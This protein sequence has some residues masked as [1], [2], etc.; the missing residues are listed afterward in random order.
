ME[1]D[2]KYIDVPYNKDGKTHSL[3]VSKERVLEWK[4]LEEK[5][6]PLAIVLS[7]GVFLLCFLIIMILISVILGD[8]YSRSGRG[9]QT[10]KTVFFIV[11]LP[12]IMVLTAKFYNFFKEYSS[13]QQ[14]KTDLQKIFNSRWRKINWV[15]TILLVIKANEKTS[16]FI[17]FLVLL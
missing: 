5:S 7:I 16:L 17:H 10:G 6:K 1:N 8:S 3:T 11:G 15:F 4:D 13:N 2:S 12:I 14:K 9:L